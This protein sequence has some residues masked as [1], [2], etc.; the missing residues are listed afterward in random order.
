MTPSAS[1]H[2]TG[3]RAARRGD[4]RA[5]RR[6]LGYLRAYRVE[7]VGA[8]LALLG[9]SAATLTAPQLVRLAVDGGISAGSW[10]TVLVAV[11]GLFAVA[12][13]RG[14]LSFAQGYLAERASQGVAYDLRDGL[15]LHI[16]RLSFSF[17]DRVQTGQLLTRLTSDV[18]Q[19]RTF[20][21]TGV[22]QLLASV[23][24]LLGTAALLL[25]LNAL[26]AVVV[27]ATVVPIVF[28]LVRFVSR[29]GPLF[30]VLQQTLGRLNTILREDVA[31]V[32]V[33]RAFAREEH[34]DARYQAVNDALRDRNVAVIHAV[35]DNFPF[36]FLFANLGTLAVTWLGGLEVMGGTLSLGELIAF[37]SYLAFLV[38]PL[39]TIGFLGAAIARAGASAARVFEVLDAP[40]DVTDRAG[41]VELPPLEVGLEMRDV[42]F[43]YPGGERDVLHGVSFRADVGQTVA[44]LGGTGSGKSTLVNLIPRFYDVTEGAVLVDGHDVRDVTL[45]SLRRQIGVVLQEARLFAGTVRENIAFGR[46]DA[47]HEEVEAAARTAQAYD[48]ITALPDGF[49]TVVGERGLT[50]SG[51]QR[52]RLAIAR[53]LVVDP[54][55]LIL[56]DSM[57]AVDTA[58]EAA[59]REALD[60]LMRDRRHTVVVIAQ[61]VSTVRDA[62]LI[63]VLDDGRIVARGTHEEL[64]RESAIYNEILGSQ[65]TDDALVPAGTNAADAGDGSVGMG[66]TGYGGEGEP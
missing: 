39:L 66:G 26:L 40:L 5:L 31:G 17:Y 28:L 59:L 63:L 64:L 4:P 41:A 2:P 46:P 38:Q 43:R 15:F 42:C 62:D 34:E 24:M 16:E 6:A 14:L 61:R 53:A 51:G 12:A 60:R 1:T 56:D 57:S 10:H 21:G 18:E 50:L 20:A 54:R 55:I 32:R 49:D 11:G 29:V 13:M 45:R 52:Q 47:T 65:L 36:I 48:F 35:G 3:P 33:V 23:V 19:I 25:S 7:T 58:T 8:F 44:L 27:L 9:V 37:S 22:V 30:G